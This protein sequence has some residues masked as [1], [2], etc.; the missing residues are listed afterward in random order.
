[1]NTVTF[2]SV[3][4][5]FQAQSGVELDTLTDL[6]HDRA[7]DLD[8]LS[9]DEPA[10]SLCLPLSVVDPEGEILRRILGVKIW[11]H[12]VR[13]ARLTLHNVL[14]YEVDDRAQI[15]AATINE[16]W[17]ADGLLTI[18]SGIPVTIRARVSDLRVTLELSEEV[19]KYQASLFP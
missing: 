12:A 15:A 5:S 16:L 9:F 3:K 1:M 4:K 17:Y 7:V 2:R 18:T 11:R 13:P 10:R 8:A 19:I 14:S 6:V